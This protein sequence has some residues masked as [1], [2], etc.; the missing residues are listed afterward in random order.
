MACHKHHCHLYWKTLTTF[1]VHI[2]CLFSVTILQAVMN[3]SGCNFSGWRNLMIHFCFIYTYMSDSILPYCFSVAIN[4]RKLMDYQW[5]V[6]TSTA[7]PTAC[8]KSSYILGRNNSL[9]W[10]FLSEFTKTVFCYVW[11]SFMI[12]S[13]QNFTSF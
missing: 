12:P 4:K 3:V 2:H 10:V 1:C 6:S 5:K 7:I 13:T 11:G 8:G 9:Q